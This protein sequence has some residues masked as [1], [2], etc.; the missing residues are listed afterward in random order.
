MGVYKLSRKSEI[1]LAEM[2][3]YGISEFGFLYA[4]TYFNKMHK[5]FQL[6]ANNSDLGRDASE[7]I[8]RLERF[9]FRVHTIFYSATEN[10][11]FIVRVLSQRKDYES[12]L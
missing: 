3:E 11:I 6:L 1:D 7:F 12:N 5:V 2:Y 9:I 8:E 10:G 4:R